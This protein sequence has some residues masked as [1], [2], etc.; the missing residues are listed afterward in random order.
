ILL[1][2]ARAITFDLASALSIRLQ[3]RLE[4][5]FLPVPSILHGST[6]HCAF[7]LLPPPPDTPANGGFVVTCLLQG[8]RPRPKTSGPAHPLGR[9]LCF[10]ALPPLRDPRAKSLDAPYRL[11]QFRIAGRVAEAEMPGQAEGRAM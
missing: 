6:S 3:L 2:C 7:A 8:Q 11:F 4:P 5:L 10:P 1:P 9:G